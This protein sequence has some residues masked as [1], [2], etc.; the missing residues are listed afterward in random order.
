MVTL[1]Q[2]VVDS[3]VYMSVRESGATVSVIVVIFFDDITKKKVYQKKINKNKNM[4]Q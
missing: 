4:C 3:P 2:I 1:N